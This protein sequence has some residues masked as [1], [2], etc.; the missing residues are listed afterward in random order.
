MTGPA[1]GLVEAVA[2]AIVED[3]GP[4]YV[5]DVVDLANARAAIAAV[6]EWDDGQ[7]RA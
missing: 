4:G 3:W 5:L 6:R 7:A 2:R 1:G